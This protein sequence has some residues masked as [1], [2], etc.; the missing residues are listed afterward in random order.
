MELTAPIEALASLK[1]PAKYKAA[2]GR[3]KDLRDL[4]AQQKSAGFE[5]RLGQF[6]A[7]HSAK[8]TFIALLDEE[9]L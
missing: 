5:P 3:L 8:R 7:R 6:R 9:G 1:L 2:V 4:Y